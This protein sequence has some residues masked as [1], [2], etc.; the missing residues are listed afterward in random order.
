MSANVR[1]YD[2][3]FIDG[4]TDQQVGTLDAPVKEFTLTADTVRVIEEISIE[5]DEEVVIWAY[6][7]AK[8]YFDLIRLQVLGGEGYIEVAI[9]S[10][11][12]TSSTDPTPLATCKGWDFVD[13]SCTAPL[14][15]TSDQVIVN[16]VVGDAH[17]DNSGVPLK[18]SDAG[19]IAGRVYKVMIR[20]P[21]DATD[22]VRLS[23][24]IAY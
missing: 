9:Y 22:A 17:N 24:A 5:P 19:T 23:K 21:A 8:P 7:A 13:L 11:A 4:S 10:D 14:Y 1:V 2:A 6:S 16:P 3:M 15:L 20:N 18:W 12:P